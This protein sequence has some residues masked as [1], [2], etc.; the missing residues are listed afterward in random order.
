MADGNPSLFGAIWRFFSFRWLRTALGI[1]RAADAQFTG[2]ARGISDAYDIER[3]KRVTTYKELEAAVG[4][5]AGV[6]EEDKLRL[7]ALNAEEKDQID[8]REGALTRVQQ[9]QEQKDGEAEARHTE[10]FNRFQTRIAEI[11]A[12]QAAIEGRMKD[13]ENALAGH[14]RTLTKLQA[15]IRDL[16][17]EKAREMAAFVSNKKIIELNDRLKGIQTSFQRGPL[18]A[19]REANRRLT[20]QAKVSQKLAGAD[21]E[22]QDADYASAGKQTAASDVMKRMLAERAA[23]KATATGATTTTAPIQ[24]TEGGGG[25]GKL[26]S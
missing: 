23:K 17:A 7:E 24:V 11:E 25:S 19:V 26:G 20:A 15:E 9:A 10:A 3:D 21:V 4:E 5:V 6:I 22:Q 13:N 2:T 14:M 8:K 16:P 12:E 18:D 1:Q